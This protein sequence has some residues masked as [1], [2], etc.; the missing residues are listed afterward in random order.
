MP[1]PHP[2]ALAH[3]LA[4]VTLATACAPPPAS[5]AP[6]STTGAGEFAAST[7][8]SAPPGPAAAPQRVLERALSMFGP[9]PPAPSEPPELV[10]LGRALF[11]ETRLSADGRVGCVTCHQPARY[12]S[13]GLARARGAF[14]REGPRNAPTV[15]NTGGQLAQHWRGDRASL[16]DQ[17]EKSLLGKPSFAL[18]SNAEA[19]RRLESLGYASA[20]QRAFPADPRPLTV[21]HFAEAIAAYEA[22]LVT[23]API[24]AFFAGKADALGPPARAGLGEFM[25]LGC[26]HCHRGPR[27]GG[28]D[29]EKFGIERDYRSAT[30]STTADA[31]RFDVTHVEADR[32]VFKVPMLRNVAHTAPYFHD[33]SVAT[34]PEAVRIMASLE[35]GKELSD[36]T[37]SDLVAFLGSLSGEVPASFSAPGGNE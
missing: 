7:A 4:L 9:L 33:G 2:V 37:V 24:D 35:L 8:S 28:L 16:A 19:A 3:A 13:D 10:A 32:D 5:R 20:F 6:A 30:H 34:L 31:G 11:F 18:A 22:T 12:G 17:A 25:E 1:R 26:G 23:P 14:G 21:S 27:F 36:D 15:F 29:F